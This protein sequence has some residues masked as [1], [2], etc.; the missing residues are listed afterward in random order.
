[1]D[2]F[3]QKLREIQKKERNI[4]GLARVGDNFY[5]DVNE[6][7]NRLMK[8]I[9]NNPFSFDSYLLRDAQRIAME[10]CE[11]RE[12]KITNSAVM[13]VQRSYQLFAEKNKFDLPST[14][15]SNST[16]EEEKLFIALVDSLTKYREEMITSF[17]VLINKRN[18]VESK[19]ESK[20]KPSKDSEI[21]NRIFESG[22]RSE[23]VLEDY[24]TYEQIEYDIPKKSIGKSKSVTQTTMQTDK[25][26]KGFVR[27]LMVLEEL[28]SIVGVD[29]KIY[30][31]FYP[32][33]VITIPEPNAKILIKRNKGRF[34][35]KYRQ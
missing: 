19:V 13:Y 15:P 28:P 12:H 18:E 22:F 32:Q 25:N 7:L 35:G 5:K 6:Y 14:V 17:W 29:K 16:P 8:R 20:R 2:E 34:V 1:M 4:S 30:G 3:F 21:E 9:D 11:R 27:T 31:P 33:D 24:K 23:N 26:K 10:I